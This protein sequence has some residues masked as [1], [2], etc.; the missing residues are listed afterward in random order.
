MALRSQT[1][2]SALVT[3][4]LEL[5]TN[6]YSEGSEVKL[7][8]VPSHIGIE[9][10]EKADEA[11]RAAVHSSCVRPLKVEADDFK[12]LINRIVSEEWQGRWDKEPDCALRRLH[13]NT[14]TWESSNRR[15]RVEEVALTRLRIGH[16]YA[17]HSHL[18]TKGAPPVCDHCGAPLTVKHVLSPR[19]ICE[20]LRAEKLRYFPDVCMGEVLGNQATVPIKKVLLYLRGIHFNIVYRP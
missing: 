19:D 13:P 9:G 12:P 20:P 8:W 5:L 1:D 14:S 4:I 16:C 6:I 10:N 3:R 2:T 15:N 18:L 17:T 7:L 11:A